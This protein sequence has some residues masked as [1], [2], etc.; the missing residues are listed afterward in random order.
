M[1]SSLLINFLILKILVKRSRSD[2]RPCISSQLSHFCGVRGRADI[3]SV[4]AL[5]WMGAG[6]CEEVGWRVSASRGG[7]GGMLFG[8]GRRVVERDCCCRC[9]EF[10][11]MIK[12]LGC[13]EV[14][15]IVKY[16]QNPKLV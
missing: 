13:R 11:I 14:G 9:C 12:G 10:L 1:C 4:P 15:F 6:L 5:E 3:A 16:E 7:A 2:A 8:V